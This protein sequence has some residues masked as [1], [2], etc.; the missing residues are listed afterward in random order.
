EVV[1]NAEGVSSGVYVVR[2]SVDPPY[3]GQQSA[4][5]LLHSTRKVV[6]VK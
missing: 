1:W 4:G 2:L 5:T 3:G 6:L